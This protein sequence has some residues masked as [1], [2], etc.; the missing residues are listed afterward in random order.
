MGSSV[1]ALR[2]LAGVTA[3]QWGMITTAQAR[4]VGISAQTMAALA[5]QEL[6]E[7]VRHGVYRMAGAPSDPADGLRAAWLAM[8][9]ELAPD[10]Q[11]TA[12]A[13]AVVSHRSAADLHG[14]GDMNAFEFEFT[15]AGRRQSRDKGI[16]FHRGTLSLQEWML[17]GGLPVTTPARTVV[18]LAREGIDGGHLAGVARDA[19]TDKHVDPDELA[20][21]LAPCAHRYGLPHQDGQGFVAYLLTVAGIPKATWLAA[22][23]ADSTWID[24][25]GRSLTGSRQLQVA[26]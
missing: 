1:V 17:V 22:V 14:L 24:S 5:K 2:A 12:D 3:Y 6:L 16:V 13:V 20:E 4:Q 9:P 8:A 23:L 19:I 18:D 21:V 25:A 10:A 7:R 26:P 15:V 11:L